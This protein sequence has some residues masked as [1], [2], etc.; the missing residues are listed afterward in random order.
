MATT[1]AGA[2]QLFVARHLPGLTD[3]IVA[4]TLRRRVRA[5]T[6]DGVPMAAGLVE[7]HGR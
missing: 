7:R 4:T 3:R 1:R 6:F 2:V 5:G